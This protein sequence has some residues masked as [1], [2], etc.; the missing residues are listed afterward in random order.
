MEIASAA[1][2]AVM[3]EGTE[4]VCTIRPPAGRVEAGFTREE[5][6]ITAN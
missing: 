2:E 4:R 1:F 5:V 6:V 3:Q